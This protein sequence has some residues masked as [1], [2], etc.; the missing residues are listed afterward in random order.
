[1]AP[2]DESRRLLTAYAKLTG[3]LRWLGPNKRKRPPRK[4]GDDLEREPVEPDRP[5][6]LQGGAAAALEYDE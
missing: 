6:P 2:S 5:R 4:G 1:M 3:N